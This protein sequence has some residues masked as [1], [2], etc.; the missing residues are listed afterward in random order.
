V[1]SS[2]GNT[3]IDFTLDET[4][5]GTV[6][7]PRVGGGGTLTIHPDGTLV[8]HDAGT[9]TGPVDGVAG[10]GKMVVN[11]SGT[12]S[13]LTGRVVL[14]DGQGCLNGVRGRF[15]IAGTAIGP[16]TFTGTYAGRV[17]FGGD[18]DSDCGQEA[19]SEPAYR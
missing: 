15:R 4:I 12:F 3:I 5:S 14:Q 7:G 10:T 11:A 18:G 2:G 17:H 19:T 13:A 6:S 1:T 8:A 9:F 16:P